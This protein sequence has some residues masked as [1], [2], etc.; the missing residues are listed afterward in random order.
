MKI[1]IV[2][3]GDTLWTIAK[4]YGV[5]FEELKKINSQLSNPEMIMP[6]M[7]IKIP[8]TGGSVKK[9][10]GHHHSSTH[11]HSKE[12]KYEHPFK[13]MKPPTVPAA[14]TP[15]QII[16]KE[17][18]K[19]K[20]QPVTPI[21]PQP[22][23]PDIEINQH[24]DVTMEQVNKQ[25]SQQV[26]KEIHKV[27][28][29]L[30][31]G[32]EESAEIMEEHESSCH[33]PMPQVEYSGCYEGSF[34]YVNPYYMNCYSA[35]IMPVYPCQGQWPQP[36]PYVQSSMT[37]VYQQPSYPYGL[38]GAMMNEP[39]E[40]SSSALLPFSE[41]QAPGMYPLGSYGNQPGFAPV[42][43]MPPVT[44]VGPYYS[45][46]YSG[47]VYPPMPN[48][49]I[50]NQPMPYQQAGPTEGKWS[51]D[52]HCQDQSGEQVQMPSYPGGLIMPV[53]PAPYQ[54]MYSPAPNMY[55]TYGHLYS[56]LAAPYGGPGYQPPFDQSTAFRAP[57]TDDEG[58]DDQ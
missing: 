54:P 4:K 57:S 31:P 19:E 58:H 20:P 28:P 52:C 34:P 13:E 27:P 39:M 41:M 45:A 3:K 21:M 32:L 42:S 49:P 47:A 15:N 7:K 26:Q 46:P 51:N 5:S 56:N 22:I 36:V 38:P 12:M 55:G 1:H 6:G 35:P 8:G 24:F 11:H 50:S 14:E 25:M 40:E 53:Q 10:S 9:G 33:P 18:P 44:G 30:F 16:K 23:V 48:Q 37:P 2:Q 29:N 43:Q 17:V